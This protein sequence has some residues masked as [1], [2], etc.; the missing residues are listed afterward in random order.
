MANIQVRD[1]DLIATFMDIIVDGQVAK[2][3]VTPGQLKPVLQ[4]HFGVSD[5]GFATIVMEYQRNQPR[6]S[7]ILSE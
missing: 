6:K 2:T 3:M 5:T 4:T 7:G 1:N